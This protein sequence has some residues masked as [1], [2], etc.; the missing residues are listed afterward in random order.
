MTQRLSYWALT[1]GADPR[2]VFDRHGWR[3]NEPAV[4]QSQARRDGHNDLRGDVRARGGD[5]LD[6]PR[7]GFPRHGRAP[8]RSPRPPPTRSWRAGATSIRLGWASPNCGRPSQLTSGGSTGL[9]S[10]PIPRCSSPRARPRRSRPHCLPLSSPATR[11]SP[12]SPTTTPTRPASRWPEPSGC[13]SPCGRRRSGPTWRRCVPPS[14]R[15]P[16]SS[17]STRRT[18]RPAACF[19][20]AELGAV[21]ALAREHDLLVVTDEVY[22]HVAFDGEHVPLVSL[23]GM[24]ER[25]V[26]ISS[27]GKT[28]S[29]TGWKI[30]WV[31]AVPELV[32]SG[33]H[34]QAVPHLC[35]RRTVSVRDR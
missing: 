30:G 1:F 20:R 25:T 2:A 28:F 7:P 35:Q 24:R 11:S 10:A 18:I 32:E 22:E 17:C 27:A 8:P 29:F 15:V 33:P 31:T 34:G 3:T 12:S 6:Q 23:P 19:T 4:S 14:R 5:R 26:S 16:G 9:R 21:A 13:R